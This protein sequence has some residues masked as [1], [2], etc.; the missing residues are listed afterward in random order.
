MS[1]EFTY[2]EVAEF[3]AKKNLHLVI[4]DKIY[5]TASFVDEHP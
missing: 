2:V 1:K 4:H 5:N 3:S